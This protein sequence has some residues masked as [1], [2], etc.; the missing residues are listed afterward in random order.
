MKERFIETINN[1]SER[2]RTI[3]TFLV[4]FLMIFVFI[5]MWYF[6]DSSIE[7]R[8]NSII[9]QETMLQKMISMKTQY[10]KAQNQLEV[11]KSSI[12]SNSVNLNSDITT[13]RE[14]IGIGISTLKEVK[15]RKKGDI[16]IER[17]EIGFRDVSLE[18]TLAFLYGIENRSRYVF[19][20][21]ITIKRRFNRENYDVSLVVAALKKEVT[22]E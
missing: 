14:S 5:G 12:S 2:E 1:L 8:K 9:E 20:D 3:L 21:A 6:M 17:A 18:Q 15:A 22:S 4:T 10:Q 13:V 11:M 19:V 16:S 7:N